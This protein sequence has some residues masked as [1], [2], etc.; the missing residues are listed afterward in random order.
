LPRWVTEHLTHLWT[1]SC[2]IPVMQQAKVLDGF[3]I[4]APALRQDGLDP[5]E[6]DIGLAQVVQALVVSPLAI[7]IDLCLNIGL[8]RRCWT[9]LLTA[10][11]LRDDADLVL[12]GM[13]LAC[14][15]ALACKHS[16]CL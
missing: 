16:A 4:G 5:V 9:D 6:I 1:S 10:K 11:H 8:K 15:T 2:C 7:V 12:G 13:A 3:V 14:I